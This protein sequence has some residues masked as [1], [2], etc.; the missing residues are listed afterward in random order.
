VT[1]SV[2]TSHAAQFSVSITENGGPPMNTYQLDE[3][4]VLAATFGNATGAPTNPTTTTLYVQTPDGLIANLTGN[5][6]I[7]NPSTGNFTATIQTTQAGPY[8]YKWQG[9]GAVEI[10]SPDQYFQV[11]QSAVLGA[12]AC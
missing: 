6:T 2:T 8:I 5:A 7:S 9:T 10:T 12:N 1:D 4:V 11:S 3:A